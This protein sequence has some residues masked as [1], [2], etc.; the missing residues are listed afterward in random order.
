MKSKTCKCNRCVRNSIQKKTRRGGKPVTFLGYFPL[1]LSTYTTG[2]LAKH[3]ISE[4]SGFATGKLARTYKNFLNPRIESNII[5][6]K[7]TAKFKPLYKYNDN[8]VDWK[9]LIEP[10]KI[11]PNYTAGP[12]NLSHNRVENIL[13]PVQ[14]DKRPKS[15]NSRS[16][17]SHRS[18]HS[19]HSNGPRYP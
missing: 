18:H 3:A 16:H 5:S 9:K 13:W 4:N 19:N 15:V 14:N 8:V 6:N 1:R 2:Q 11:N 17:R 12:V 7:S 10:V